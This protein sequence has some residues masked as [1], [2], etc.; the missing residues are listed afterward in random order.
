[1]AKHGEG[2][3]QPGR[4]GR[5]RDKQG[6]QGKQPLAAETVTERA[7][8]QRTDQAAQQRAALSPADLQ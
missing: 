6:G 7:R 1:M 3:R 8:H 5:C 2:T 4:H